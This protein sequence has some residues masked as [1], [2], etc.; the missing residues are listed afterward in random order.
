MFWKN[1]RCSG[2]PTIY[3]TLGRGIAQNSKPRMGLQGNLREE[4]ANKYKIN[5]NLAT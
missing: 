2:Q 5:G 3:S 4:E 1:F